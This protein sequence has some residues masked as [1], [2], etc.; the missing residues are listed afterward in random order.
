[1]RILLGTVVF[2]FLLHVYEMAYAAAAGSSM[3]AGQQEAAG[4][5][6]TLITNHDDIVAKAKTEGKLRVLAGME[7][8]T[9]KA[10]TAGFTKKYPF[11]DLTVQEFLG[12]D[13]A[14]R[15]FLEIKSGAKEWE[16]NVS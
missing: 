16:N 3:P 7:P 14:Q 8:A 9:I 6:Y 5:G 11:V 10:T 1:M 4:G 2:L 12:T 13:A 15:N